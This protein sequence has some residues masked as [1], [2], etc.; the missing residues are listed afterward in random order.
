MRSLRLFVSLSPLSVSSSL[1][2]FVSSSLRNKVELHSLR[3]VLEAMREDLDRLREE[4][5]LLHQR[6]GIVN[7]EVEDLR[8]RES[9]VASERTALIRSMNDARRETKRLKRSVSRCLCYISSTLDR[10]NCQISVLI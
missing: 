2:L 7:N 10:L 5:D 1:C 8:G 3:E 6:V 4:R 9:Q